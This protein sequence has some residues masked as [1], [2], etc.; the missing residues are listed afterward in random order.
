VSSA[1]FVVWVHD[2]YVVVA[3]EE[4]DGEVVYAAHNVLLW[5]RIEEASQVMIEE[6][7]AAFWV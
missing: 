2:E 5:Y 4:L 3:V 7:K 6:A 1:K